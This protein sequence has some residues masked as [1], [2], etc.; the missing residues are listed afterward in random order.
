MQVKDVM[1]RNAE[2][3]DPGTTSRDAARKMKALNVGALPIGENDRL[4]GMVTDRDIALRVVAE[5]KDP[6]DTQVR[7]V[8]TSGIAYCFDDDDLQDAAHVMEENKIRRLTVLNHDKRLVGIFSL[9][10]LAA[11]SEDARL[12][13]EVLSEVSQP[14]QPTR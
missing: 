5:E 6:A 1:T 8:M 2:W 7:D 3:I 9:G 13:S 12:T 11:H 10:D 4:I 14:A